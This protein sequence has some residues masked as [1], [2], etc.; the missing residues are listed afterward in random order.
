MLLAPL[1]S[2][3]Q[4]PGLYSHVGVGEGTWGLMVTDFTIVSVSHWWG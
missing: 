4:H 1:L 3:L 2:F